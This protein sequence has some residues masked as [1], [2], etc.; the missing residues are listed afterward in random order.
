M[1]LKYVNNNIKIS[2]KSPRMVT[3]PFVVNF[4]YYIPRFSELKKSIKQILYA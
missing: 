3:N 1:I 2:K 4:F